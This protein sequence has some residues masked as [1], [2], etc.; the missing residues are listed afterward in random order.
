MGRIEYRGKWFAS[1]PDESVL[2]ALLRQGAELS[3]SCRK[4]S[5]Q[6]CVQ[7]LLSGDVRSNSAC[8]P[9]LTADGHLLPCV[10]VAQGDIRL[11]PPDPHHR[12][13]EVELVD[14]RALTADIVELSLAPLRE[15]PF[16]A[17]QHV[18][19]IRDDGLSRPYSL[20]SLPGEEY[21]FRVHIRRVADGVM[22]R[23][24]ADELRLGQKLHLRGAFGCAHY[25]PS[26]RERP[27]ALLATGVGAGAMLALARDALSQNH[28][29]PITLYHGVRCRWDLYLHDQLTDLQARHRNFRYVPA[30]SREDGDNG[31][32]HGRITEVAFADADFEEHTIVLCGSPAMVA[33]ARWRALQA[34]A[35]RTRIHA[36]PYL[37][38]HPAAPADAARIA[39]IDAEPELWAALE[40]GPGLTR[41]LTH[42][43]ARVFADPQLAPFF[44]QITQDRAIQKQYEFLA[45]LMSGK[46][47]YFGLNPFNAHHWMVISDEL[48]DYREE[49][50]EQVLR[51]DGL[52]I[53]LIRRWMAMHERFRS[54]IVK[55]V[56]RG[57][58]SQGIEQ[59]LHSH[60]I[61]RLSIDTVCDG[62]GEEIPA[63]HPS[64]YQY[65]SGTLHCAC[66]AGI[67][68]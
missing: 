63:Q 48:F 3:Y 62:C 37:Y 30:V 65:R 38:Q 34:G 35:R 52:P 15:L 18:Q 60:V 41:I 1:E 36:D 13:I 31:I 9:Q 20:V 39:A 32:Q 55:V 47:N 40:S 67:H 5:C 24:L 21:Y 53:A 25:G 43:Y 6:C 58:I 33:E 49:M 19:L 28:R 56:P 2:D 23:W 12:S 27:L 14:R 45:D 29:E 22:S 51:D 61:E 54:D 50:F 66:C 26:M 68:E 4:G 64:R 8:D 59:P 17:G 10:S 46:R 42:F 57:L 7:R 16:H 44:Q 11:A